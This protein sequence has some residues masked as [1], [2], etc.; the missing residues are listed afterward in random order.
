MSYGTNIAVGAAQ[1]TG[2]LITSNPVGATVAATVGTF[3]IP[4]LTAGASKAAVAAAVFSGSWFLAWAAIP[5]IGIMLG[6]S[7]IVPQE[8][9]AQYRA[10]ALVLGFAN[11]IFS[12]GIAAS[13]LTASG[14]A[15]SFAATALSVLAGTGVMMLAAAIVAGGLATCVCTGIGDVVHA[16]RGSQFSN[17][18]WR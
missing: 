8:R 11:L 15:V 12:A 17:D 4:S 1:V 16:G 14:V 7:L 3:F 13:A 5:M 10:L 9:G 18:M 6:M 2:L